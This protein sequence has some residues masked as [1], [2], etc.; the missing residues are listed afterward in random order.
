[1]RQV[2]PLSSGWRFTDSPMRDEWLGE[3][4]AAAEPGSDTVALGSTAEA[5]AAILTSTAAWPAW[6]PVDLP[7]TLVTLPFNHFDEASYRKMG[8]YKREF[9]SPRIPEGGSVFLDFEGVAVSCRLWL[10]GRKIGGHSGPYTPFSIDITETIRRANAVDRANSVNRAAPEGDA[11]PERS[12]AT[13]RLFME[14][15]AREDPAVPPFGGVVDYLVYGGIYRAVHLRVQGPCR[16][17]RVHAR[18][19]AGCAGDGGAAGLSVDVEVSGAARRGASI[20]AFLRKDGVVLAEARAEVYA[21]AQAGANPEGLSEVPLRG[22]AVVRVEFR[23]LGDI[24]LWDIDSPTLYDLDVVLEAKG[25]LLDSVSERIGFRQ[26]RFTPDGFYLNG[27]RIFLRGL[28]RHQS[29]PYVGYAMGPGA[30]RRD[31][32]ILKRELGAVIVRT[33]H[34]PQSRH[35]LDA[36]DELGLLVFT[37]LPGWQHIGDDA[38]KD[39]ALADLE[40]LIL[41]DRNHPSVILWGVRVNESRDDR[42]FYE[43]TNALSRKLDPDRQTGGVRCIRKS[44]FL[45]DVYTFN[46][47][48]GDGGPAVVAKP[49]SVTGLKKDVPYLITEHS[50]HMFPT[51][52]FDQEER[53]AE[54]ARRHAAVLDASMGDPGISGAIGWCAFDYNTH[55]DFGSG[56]RV[57]YHGVSDMFRIPKYAAAVYA[58]Q[59]DPKSK[60]V[61][62]PASLFSKGERSAA[63]ILPVEVYTNCDA[64]ELYRAGKR[65][66]CF[67]P[68]RK[69]YPHLE[70]PPVLIDDFIGDSIDG[71]GFSPR[72]KG[73]F[74][75][76]AGKAMAK[77]AE[78]FSLLDRL[79]FGLLLLRRRMSFQDAEALVLSYGLAWGK[80]DDSVE[81]VGM[82]AGREV[83]RKS[84][85]ADARAERLEIKADAQAIKVKPGDEWDAVRVVASMRDQYGNLCP[86][87]FEPLRIEISGAGRLIGP[88]ER[89]L[90]GGATAFWVAGVGACGDIEVKV[91]NWRFGSCGLTLKAEVDHE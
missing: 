57:C 83:I 30:Q 36:C 20:A 33:S 86:F 24:A 51:K 5:P 42:A 44:D 37:E 62:E 63:R 64:V 7:H 52:R 89:S 50:G 56:D 55:K 66:G 61:L 18:P 31:A 2:F 35:F 26:A 67:H 54:H 27:K 77:G 73:V 29:W 41:R 39:R 70:H 65:I 6:I 90:S 91:T 81:L 34:Y 49:R 19:R 28:N 21:E 72:D 15:A 1:M 82:I 68:D 16:I 78:N 53:L 22:E 46:D 43:K 12:A 76:L 40:A 10:N 45:E 8:T 32:E 88:C 9:D 25:E 17:E 11:S 80:A 14:V 3:D 75:S 23:K 84:F 85:G 74:L 60:I 38:W 13:N 79:R 87:A 4:S 58:S 59:V 69:T 47:F 48:S 71:E